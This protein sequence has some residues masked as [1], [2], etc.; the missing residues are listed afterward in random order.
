MWLRTSETG[1]SKKG[2]KSMGVA[3]QY[4]G[5]AGKGE[6][7]H[8]GTLLGESMLADLAQPAGL[9]LVDKAA[10]VLLV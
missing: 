7:C 10:H 9:N 2:N 5:T 3:R 4:P 1:F 6:S 8:V